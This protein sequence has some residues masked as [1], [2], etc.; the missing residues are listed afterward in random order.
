MADLIQ[1]GQV[2]EAAKRKEW[3]SVLVAIVRGALVAANVPATIG[4]TTVFVNDGEGVAV[5]EKT[6]DFIIDVV[7]YKFNGE[8]T[9]PAPGDAIVDYSSGEPI[10]YRVLPE[11]GG[12]EKRWSDDYGIAWRVSTK[13]DS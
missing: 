12:S 2:W 9:E 8:V 6:R 5:E 10:Y 7:D 3:R 1:Q 4:S 11:A 13:R